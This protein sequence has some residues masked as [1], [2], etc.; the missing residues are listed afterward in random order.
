MLGSFWIECDL[1]PVIGSLQQTFQ[2]AALSGRAKNHPK[3]LLVQKQLT[4]SKN[5]LCRTNLHLLLLNPPTPFGRTGRDIRTYWKG[6]SDILEGTFGRTSIIS[7]ATNTTRLKF[8]N[9]GGLLTTPRGY[10]PKW[11]CL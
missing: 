6:H 7:S 10:S 8:I 5:S 4:Y 11:K 9:R 3:R 1:R 2:S